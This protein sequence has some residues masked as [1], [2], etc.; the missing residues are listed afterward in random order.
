MSLKK[1][2]FV[3]KLVILSL[4][5]YIAVTLVNMRGRIDQAERQ[6]AQL[7]SQV[8]QLAAS[9]AALE[10]EIQHSTDP[11]TIE[12]ISRE[13]LGLVLPGEIVYYDISE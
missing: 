4:V 7:A 3:T 5:L 12:N 2:G 8:K 10:Y 11:E 1:A 13:K 9:N 6:Q